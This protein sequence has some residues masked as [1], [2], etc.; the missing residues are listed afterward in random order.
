MRVQLSIKVYGFVN[1]YVN[2][3]FIHNISYINRLNLVR[4]F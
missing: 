1:F 2:R 3:F 4:G